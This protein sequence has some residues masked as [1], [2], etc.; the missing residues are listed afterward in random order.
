[1]PNDQPGA[2]GELPLVWVGLGDQPV[3]SATK[4]LIQMVAP[5]EIVF[6]VGQVTPPVV[7]GE[8]PEEQLR[9]VP[10]IE[11]RVLGKYGLTALRMKELINL[12]QMALEGHDQM[13]KMYGGEK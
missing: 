10:F 13:L 6:T 9:S 4:F 8:T 3:V 5:D 1:M 11:V 2:P 7:V 12:L